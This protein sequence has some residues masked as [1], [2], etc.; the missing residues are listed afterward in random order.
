MELIACGSW[1]GFPMWKRILYTTR[2]WIPWVLGA[3]WKSRYIWWRYVLWELF[4]KK[5]VTW[6]DLIKNPPDEE[7]KYIV[8]ART[9]F[10]L[11]L[12]G[13]GHWLWYESRKQLEQE[14]ERDYP[15]DWEGKGTGWYPFW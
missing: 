10:F 9:I 4:R 2:Y 15:I 3:C 7:F 5:R 11:Y 14:G 8:E 13:R 12:S 1:L 6:G